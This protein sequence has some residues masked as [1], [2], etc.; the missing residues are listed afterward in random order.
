M[1]YI[2]VKFK[3][4]KVGT[5]VDLILFFVVVVGKLGLPVSICIDPTCVNAS[6]VICFDTYRVNAI[7]KYQHLALHFYSTCEKWRGISGVGN[8]KHCDIQRRVTNNQSI[9]KSCPSIKREI[10]TETI[11]LFFFFPIR[12]VNCFNK[13]QLEYKK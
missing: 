4:D 1:L 6:W 13:K 10:K 2:Y 9:T 8:H 11:I 3:F 5:N 12:K 7:L